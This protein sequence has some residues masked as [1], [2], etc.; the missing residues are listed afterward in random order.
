MGI[1]EA[2][3]VGKIK[4]YV[5]QNQANAPLYTLKHVFPAARIGKKLAP[6]FSA[7]PLVVNLGLLL[8]DIGY[9][10][11]YESQERDHIVRGIAIARPVLSDA[12][13][14]HSIVDAVLDTIRT[15]DGRLEKDSPVE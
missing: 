12:G 9:H 8:H 5:D 11:T 10:K 6:M 15:H 3:F 14:S 2:K 13:F 7:D 4:I 1:I